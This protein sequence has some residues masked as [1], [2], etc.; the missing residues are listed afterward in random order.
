VLQV[1]DRP[2]R[3]RFSLREMDLLGLFASQAAIAL[4]LLRSARRASAVLA[5]SGDDVGVVA[6]LAAALDAL[7][8]ERRE[9]GLRLLRDLDRVLR[10]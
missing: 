8:G 9:A 5:G 4:Q 1:L 2:Q 7:E 6:R 3:S 10:P